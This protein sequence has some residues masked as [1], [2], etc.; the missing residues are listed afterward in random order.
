MSFKSIAFA[1][2]SVFALVASPSLAQTAPTTAAAPDDAEAMADIIVTGTSIRGVAPVGTPVTGITEAQLTSRG[3]STVTEAI[4]QLPQI[5]NLGIADTQF[6]SANNANANTSAATGINLRGFGTEATLVVLN[7][8][9]LPTGGV[10]G[11]SS[12]VDPSMIPSLAVRGVEVMSDG[13]SAIYGAD[14]VGGVVNLLTRRRYDGAEFSGK[15]GFADSM[16]Q[17]SFDGI[18][19]KDWGTGSIWVAATYGERTN[20]PATARSFYTDYMVPFGG[21]DL[22]S[23]NGNPGNILVGTTRYGIP[24]GSS[25]VGLLPSQLLT[26]PN[27]ETIY[28]G[29]DVLPSQRRR[30]AAGRIS[31]DLAPGITASLEG[32]VSRRT[33]VRN[34]TRQEVNLNVPKS[35]PFFVHPTNPAA[36]SVTV[37]Y[38]WY[39]DLGANRTEG[40]A[41]AW[42]GTADIEADLGK[43]WKALAYAGAGYTSD[44]SILTATNTAAIAAALADTNPATALNPFGDGSKTNPATLAK[45]RAINDISGIFRN[46]D[47]GVK[48]DGPLLDL[49]AGALR[50]ALGAE[51]H[52]NS[53]VAGRNSN[54]GSANNTIFIASKT[55]VSRKIDSVFSEL[56]V[57]VTSGS[58]GMGELTLSAAGRYDRYSDFGSTFNPKFGFTWK[59]AIGV[60]LRGSYGTSYRAPTLGDL[61]V[62]GTAGIQVLNFVDAS[63]PIGQTKTLWIRGGNADLRP[64]TAKMFSLGADLKPEWAPGLNVSV[65]YFNVDYTNRIE[66][67]GNDTSALNKQSTLGEFIIRNPSAAL[68]QSWL[69]NPLYVGGPEDP[70][71]ILAYVDGRKRNSGQVKSRGLEISGTYAFDSRDGSW[72][73]GGSATH[74]FSMKRRLTPT[75]SVVN[76]V[77][78]LNNPISWQARGQIGYTDNGGFSA[79][80]Y[81]NY[82]GGYTNNAVTPFASIKP[83]ATVDVTLGYEFAKNIRLTVDIRNLTNQQPPFVVNGLLAFDPQIA[84]PVGRFIQFGVRKRF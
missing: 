52:Y 80:A 28:Q 45:I 1:S 10:L 37:L 23:F 77:S 79:L 76:I 64:E 17:F 7:G 30:S 69:S 58:S 50:V 66:T 14:A 47:F 26:T 3:A 82:A 41:D 12:Y 51:H 67:P 13:G 57:P 78:T 34:S 63:S 4:R 54:Q 29:S 15:Y 40:T 43:G 62:A 60:S 5:F 38:S 6:S 73:V 8:R 2:A 49:P 59:T 81:L 36:T 11:N 21:T 84:D 71:T 16:H 61:N 9:R 39:D 55:G 19:G 75:S 35:N 42:Y 20:L 22:R 25:G 65:T 46:K 31:Q 48:V 32:F 27:R 33:A 70:A 72:S 83:Y 68:I 44:R 24:A 53:Q 56:Y 18:V 74:L